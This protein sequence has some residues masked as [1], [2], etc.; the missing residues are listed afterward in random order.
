MRRFRGAQLTERV[1]QVSRTQQE[2]QHRLLRLMRVVEGAETRRFENNPSDGGG[3][4]R[5]RDGDTVGHD[6]R[7][8]VGGMS[9]DERVLASR[10]R[11]LQGALSRSATALPRRVDALAAAHRA[12]KTADARVAN[13]GGSHAAAAAA[14]RAK[15]EEERALAEAAERAKAEAARQASPWL[16]ALSPKKNRSRSPTASRKRV[17]LETAEA[18]TAV[19]VSTKTATAWTKPPRWRTRGSSRTRRTRRG[20]WRIFLRKI[21]GTSRCCDA[22]NRKQA[23]TG[24]GGSTCLITEGFWGLVEGVR[25]NARS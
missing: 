8:G 19:P 14:A 18:A 4:Y 13:G 20:G 5:G 6:G 1:A 17:R 9:E 24:R 3:G 12:E 22:K 15:A 2:Q 23:S 11:R 7:R 21:L 10:L 16:A 25:R